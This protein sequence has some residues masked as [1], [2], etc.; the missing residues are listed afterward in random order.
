MFFVFL[1][2]AFWYQPGLKEKADNIA[3][4]SVLASEI[5]EPFQPIPLDIKL[6]KEK[7]KQGEKL[8]NEPQLSH[9]NSISCVSCH[10]LSK[11]GTEQKVSSIDGV[12]GEGLQG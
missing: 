11:G 5:N 1:A 12:M 3:L 6:N 2:V 10:A 8:F 4:E 9:D 7:V